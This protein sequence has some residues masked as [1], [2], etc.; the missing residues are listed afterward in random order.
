[1]DPGQRHSWPGAVLGKRQEERTRT[2]QPSW[3]VLGELTFLP[4]TLTCNLMKTRFLC[5]FPFKTTTA[6]QNGTQSTPGSEIPLS[7]A[8][9]QR[10]LGCSAVSQ[11]RDKSRLL[12]GLPCT[13]S[14]LHPSA[15]GVPTITQRACSVGW[16]L[17]LCSWQGLSGRS[18]RGQIRRQWWGVSALSFWGAVGGFWW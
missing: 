10:H 11:P 6:L 8:A 5:K 4:E 12:P 18:I 14:R 2:V 15:A 9:N 13:V 7:T 17:S 1:M 16:C 3:Q